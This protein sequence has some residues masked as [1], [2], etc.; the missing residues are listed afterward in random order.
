MNQGS[1]LG[2]A[3]TRSGGPLRDSV[4]LADLLVFG[5]RYARML[6]SNS[7]TSHF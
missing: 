1:R 3:W 2:A 5:S 4:V 6:Q 7:Q